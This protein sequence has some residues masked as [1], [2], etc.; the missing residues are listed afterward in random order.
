MCCGGHLFE[1]LWAPVKIKMDCRAVR[2]SE[3]ARGAAISY[4]SKHW[5]LTNLKSVR[6]YGYA[7]FNSAQSG[8][9][10]GTSPPHL[11]FPKPTYG[12]TLH[13]FRQRSRSHSKHWASLGSKWRSKWALDVD[14]IAIP[15]W[16]HGR[17]GT[18]WRTADDRLESND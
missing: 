1:A 18:T 15:T 5:L 7:S 9:L 14:G 16:L 2:I 8:P 13:C 4:L 17:F 3:L 11:A 6:S 10:S 12:R